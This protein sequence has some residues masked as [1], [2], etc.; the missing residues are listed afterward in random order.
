MHINGSNARR[1]ESLR[2][3]STAHSQHCNEKRYCSRVRESRECY[4]KYIKTYL[5]L[6][7]DVCQWVDWW[8]RCLEHAVI[9]IWCNLL[10]DFHVYMAKN[11]WSSGQDRFYNRYF[12]IIILISICMA[13]VKSR[14]RA[15]IETFWPAGTQTM[16]SSVWCVH[17]LLTTY[18]GG[19]THKHVRINSTDDGGRRA[20]VAPRLWWPSA[21]CRLCRHAVALARSLTRS[22]RETSL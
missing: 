21:K 16:F 1:S 14:S 2:S 10:M 4:S 17:P 9:Q 11:C 19:E 20:F 8:S 7:V 22:G 13:I 18:A 15:Q 12:S 5:W 6:L 3:S